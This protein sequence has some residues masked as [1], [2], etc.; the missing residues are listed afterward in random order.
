MR[1]PI[2]VTAGSL[3]AALLIGA[4]VNRPLRALAATGGIDLPRQAAAPPAPPQAAK[5]A[6]RPAGAAPTE[7]D[8]GGLPTFPGSQF[9]GSYDASRGQRFYLFGATASFGEVIAYYKALLKQKGELVFDEPG[10]YVFDVGKFRE[11]TMAFP[12][13]ITVKDYSTGG[14]KGY[15]NPKPGAQPSRFP[16]VVQIVPLPPGSADVPKR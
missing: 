14:L 3:V 2:V 16:T 11:D 8:L 7:A 4:A 1:G 5:A 13:G 10:V 12:P 15:R 9:L 6:P